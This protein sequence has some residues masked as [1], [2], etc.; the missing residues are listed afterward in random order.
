MIHTH[1]NYGE[2]SLFTASSD[3]ITI[4]VLDQDRNE[5]NLA[6]PQLCLGF[7]KRPRP[8]ASLGYGTVAGELAI[9]CS[10]AASFP[11]SS[12]SCQAIDA[13]LSSTTWF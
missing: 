13:A 3:V 1:K 5:V 6:L 7:K 11:I 8:L 12:P 2:H 4:V 9:K 10:N